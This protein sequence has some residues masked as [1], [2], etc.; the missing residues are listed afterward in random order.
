MHF[1]IHTLL[2]LILFSY[3]SMYVLTLGL[4]SIPCLIKIHVRVHQVNNALSNEVPRTKT[5]C[6]GQIFLCVCANTA[7]LNWML[8][9]TAII[10]LDII[11]SMTSSIFHVFWK[12]SSDYKHLTWWLCVM[13]ESHKLWDSQ[14]ASV[15]EVTDFIH[16]MNEANWPPACS[17]TL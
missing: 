14:L 7:K 6:L 8:V 17:S 15:G 3:M 16:Q 9:F 11:L 5:P 10:Q 2:I 4:G 12:S 13:I 1:Y